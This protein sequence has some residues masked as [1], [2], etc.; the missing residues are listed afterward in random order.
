MQG[1]TCP[2]SLG[3]PRP[4]NSWNTINVEESDNIIET[5]MR[6][7]MERERAFVDNCAVLVRFLSVHDY[8]RRIRNPHA[9]AAGLSG[10][11]RQ[12]AKS[13]QVGLDSII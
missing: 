2:N 11:D 1:Q 13:G 9:P 3:D 7:S 12:V 5:D 6:D 8:V 10:L 4:V